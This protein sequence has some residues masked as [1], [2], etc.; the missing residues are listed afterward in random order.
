MLHSLMPHA[1]P[2]SF[3]PPPRPVGPV[4][5]GVALVLWPWAGVGL[6]LA[7]LRIRGC[8][9]A[10]CVP[11]GP[12]VAALLV[13]GAGLVAGDLDARVTVWLLAIGFLVTVG[14]RFAA[15]EPVASREAFSD[16]LLLGLLT[17]AAVTVVEALAS[18]ATPLG[19]AYRSQAWWAHPNLWG[20]AVLAPAVFVTGEAL[21]RALPGR[22]F[23]ALLTGAVVAVGSGS[24]AAV[25]GL[26]T[27][28]ALVVL[29]DLL[30]RHG[31][32]WSRPTLVA[33]LVLVGLAGLLWADAGWRARLLGSLGLPSQPTPSRN[34]FEASEDLTDAVWWSP[35][36]LVDRVAAVPDT[37]AV[38]RLDRRAGRWTDRLQQRV[39]LTPE[40]WYS[41]SAEVLVDG[42]VD[43]VVAF[44]GWGARPEGAVEVVVR[45][46][47]GA[48]PRTH[49]AG[50]SQV[51][52][53][54][55]A[56]EGEGWRRLQAVFRVSGDAPVPME[57]G[58]APQTVVGEADAVLVR[59]LQFEAGERPG[60]YDATMVPDR[61][62]AIAWSAVRSRLE[63]YQAI[64]ERTFDR[65]W[66][67]WGPSGFAAAKESERFPVPR[68]E[69][70][71]SLVLFFA[72]RYGAVGLL[73]LLVV[74]ST[75]VRHGSRAVAIVVAVGLTN[76][77]DLTF[78]SD[79]VYVA[80]AL[81]VAVGD[82][83]PAPRRGPAEALAVT[84]V[85]KR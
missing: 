43:P 49:L 38:H 80:T 73:A 59:R 16:G 66:T 79:A 60:P 40:A 7:T 77:F 19:L 44:V 28:V 37:P 78:V 17:A 64:A 13:L 24:R 47:L 12:I 52:R 2:P 75:L 10:W 34:L 84:R 72:L 22:V 29:G 55:F 61:T 1:P 5:A 8:R 35:N 21:A 41:F 69:H 9:D 65:P 11:R 31:A 3:P 85:S 36:V 58:L 67:G 56:D 81:L 50:G 83:R 46:P 71:H 14:R 33:V 23:V 76:L 42:Q 25:V 15:A 62:A 18:G 48:E 39:S 70:E 20:A 45:F 68:V 82:S 27:G 30:R 32:R 53:A 63:A 4:V 51:S 6:L 54:S 26:V 74:V 57:V